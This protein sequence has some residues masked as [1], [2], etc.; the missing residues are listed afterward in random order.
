MKVIILSD[1]SHTMILEIGHN[2][3][4][5]NILNIIIYIYVVWIATCVKIHCCS[6]EQ[7]VTCASHF[8]C[9]FLL[10][11]ILLCFDEIKNITPK[12]VQKDLSINNDKHELLLKDERILASI[13]LFMYL[14]IPT[15][16]ISCTVDALTVST[17][18]SFVQVWGLRPWQ[19][20]RARSVR[21]PCSTQTVH[22]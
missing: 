16:T 5:F 18:L 7:W 14:Y 22:L 2:W 19:H 15:R 21:A 4:V 9:S 10:C 6:G 17:T 3:K 12:K 8:I 11:G 13:F 20:A 1:E